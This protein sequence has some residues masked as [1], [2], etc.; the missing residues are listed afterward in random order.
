LMTSER[1]E[2]QCDEGI[3]NAVNTIVQKPKFKRAL[4]FAI[5]SLSKSAIESGTQSRENCFYLHR[6]K[7]RS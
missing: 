7:S 5:N 2:K 4:N 6:G 3:N 1:Y